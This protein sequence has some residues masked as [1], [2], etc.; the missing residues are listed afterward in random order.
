MALLALGVAIYVGLVIVTQVLVAAARHR[1]VAWSW[2]SGLIAGG[3]TAVLVPGL[4][5]RAELSFLAGTVV[6][7]LVGVSLVLARRPAREAVGV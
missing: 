7:W 2:L 5:A 6:A 1:D 4:L 3:V